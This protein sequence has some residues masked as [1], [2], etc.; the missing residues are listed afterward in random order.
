[1]L[2]ALSLEQVQDARVLVL[3]LHLDAALFGPDFQPVSGEVSTK[4]GNQASAVCLHAA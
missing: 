1:V 4:W 3:V 2:G